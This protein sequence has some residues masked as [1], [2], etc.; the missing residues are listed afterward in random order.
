[1]NISQPAFNYRQD[2]FF[3]FFWLLFIPPPAPS[4]LLQ[5]SEE[6]FLF[7]NLSIKELTNIL[8]M[9]DPKNTFQV[10]EW[11]RQVTQMNKAESPLRDAGCIFAQRTLLSPGLLIASHES[12]APA[13]LGARGKCLGKKRWTG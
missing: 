13:L 5:S 11:G 1:M 6:E 4:I 2:F 9:N 12:K 3:F 8:L 10:V 7:C